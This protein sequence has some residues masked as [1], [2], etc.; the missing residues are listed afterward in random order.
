MIEP[1]E[2]ESKATLDAFIT[3]MKLIAKEADENPQLLHNAPTTTPV[4]RLDGVKAA[5][6]PNLRFEPACT[7]C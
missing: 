2:S 6:Q 4:G 5:R 7:I 1:T 3:T